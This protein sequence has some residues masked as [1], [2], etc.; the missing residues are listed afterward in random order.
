VDPCSFALQTQIEKLQKSIRLHQYRNNTLDADYGEIEKTL[1][2]MKN[3]L[4]EI[5]EP[6][7]AELQKVQREQETVEQEL[8]TVNRY[9]S[10]TAAHNVRW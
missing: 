10:E 1:E 9:V 2:G 5:E 4:E 7:S 6:A 3:A 8:D